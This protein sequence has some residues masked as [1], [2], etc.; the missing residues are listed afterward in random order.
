MPKPN[1]TT[2]ACSSVLVNRLLS[3][4]KGCVNSNPK[5]RP[6]AS[7]GLTNDVTEAI[8]GDEDERSGLGE[9]INHEIRFGRLG[10]ERIPQVSPRVPR[11][12]RLAQSGWPRGEPSLVH[13]IPSVSRSLQP[14]RYRRA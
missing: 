8:A 14:H 6:S 10:A 4:R 11:S 9:T 5:I 3:E 2:E 1:A 7:G 13:S 12:S